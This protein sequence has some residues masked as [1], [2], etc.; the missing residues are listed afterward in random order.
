MLPTTVLCSF[1][2]LSL[3]QCLVGWQPTIIVFAQDTNNTG[4]GGTLRDVLVDDENLSMF[5]QA[6]SELGILEAELDDPAKQFT[7]FAPTNQAITS[8]TFLNLYYN[9]I[10]ND[11][12]TWHDHLEGTVRN[13]MV[14]N[15]ALTTDQIFDGTKTHLFSLQDPLPLQHSFRTIGNHGAQVQ[16]AN[17]PASNGLLHVVDRVLE[18]EFYAQSLKQL[19]LQS[20]LDYDSL[21]RVSL[22]TIVDFVNG[23]DQYTHLPPTGQTHVACRIRAL[24]RI[25]LFYLPDTLNRSP[26]IKFGEFL[27]ASNRDETIHNLIQYSLPHK[28]YYLDDVPNGYEEWILSPNNCSHML[29]TKSKAGDLCFNDACVVESPQA[30]QFL[31]N[32]GVGYV[33]DKCVVCSGVGML[34]DYAS[35]YTETPNLKDAAQFWETSEWN[36]RNL[37]MSTGNGSAIT[38]LAARDEAFNI[39]NPEDV[40]RISTDMWK[41]HQWN[42]LNHNMLQGIYLEADFARLWEENLGK[43]YNLTALSGENVTFDYDDARKVVLIQGGDM[44]KSNIIGL[45]GVMHFIENLPVPKSVTHTVYDIAAEWENFTTQVTLIDTVFLKQDM[46]RLSPITGLFAPNSDWENKVIELEDI[47]KSVL[48]NMIFADLQWCSTLRSKVGE[49]LESHNGQTWQISLNTTTNMPCFDM[50]AVFGGPVRQSCVTKCDILVRNGIVHQIDHVLFFEVPETVGPQPPSIPTMRNPNAPVFWKSPTSPTISWE[51][52][53]PTFYGPIN[54]AYA[55]KG[56]EGYGDRSGATANLRRRPGM[57][58]LVVMAVTTL[59]VGLF[60]G[61]A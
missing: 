25:G 54:P 41:N 7:L 53:R 43:P 60:V 2:L 32:N 48:E 1:V 19:E 21:G 30:R 18:P 5:R 44:I 13:H 14:E 3:L 37:S 24:N 29:V 8:N 61:W 15:V 56:E 49:R 47:S 17:L 26:E 55:A 11:P 31:A 46:R 28:N 27:N 39:F 34:L 36:L 58:A 52:P 45:D 10:D 59:M 35:R 22:R 42:F 16:S 23:F 6:L 38:L 4:G 50:E 33:V 51:L 57:T 20:E 12:P 9:G 40:S